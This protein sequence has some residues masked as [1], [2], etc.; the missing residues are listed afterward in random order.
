[1]KKSTKER[2]E[3]LL[4]TDARFKVFKEKLKKLGY[5]KAETAKVKQVMEKIADFGMMSD[6]G[7]KKVARAV[8][9]SKNE[10]D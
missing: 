10:K 6:A 8:A 7:N 5:V 3:K 2:V 1:M 4:T 9:Q